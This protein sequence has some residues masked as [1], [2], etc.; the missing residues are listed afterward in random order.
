MTET[1]YGHLV[2]LA[3]EAHLGAGFAEDAGGAGA[4]GPE[5]ENSARPGPT[6]AAAAPNQPPAG[7]H[8][9]HLHGPHVTLAALAAHHDGIIC[10]TGGPEGPLSRL[11]EEGNGPAAGA[12]L[13]KLKPIFA[14]RLYVELPPHGSRHAPRQER[15]EPALLKLAYDLELPIVA[16]NQPYFAARD[17]FESHD[18]LRCIAEGVVVADG[19]RMRLTPEHYFKS[20]DEMAKLFADLPEALDSTVEIAMRCAFRAHTRQ[21]I[22]PRFAKSGSDGRDAQVKAEAQLLRRQAEEG[23]EKRFGIF[24][25]APG[26]S[27]DDYDKQLAHELSIIEQMGFPGYFLIV[28]DFIGWAKEHDIPVGPGRGSGAGSLVAWA[29]A[30]TD[31]DP[32]RFSLL[33]ER[34]L[35]PER[36]SMPDFDID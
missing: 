15:V 19:D 23:L 7:Q 1:G 6:L 33:F 4:A 17:D 31:I 32:M 16:T 14:D 27:R 13:A 35:N 26:F 34:F 25:P 24:Q 18:A 29:L 9:S 5:R 36:V 12:L 21:P 8:A 20:A 28:A 22:L 2:K 3:S 30:I 10:L 11:L